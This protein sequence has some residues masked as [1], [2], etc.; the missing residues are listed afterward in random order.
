MKRFAIVL[1]IG[2]TAGLVSLWAADVPTYVGA[3][4]CRDCHKT[5]KQGKQH[6]LWEAGKHAQSFNNLKPE[7]AK[8]AAGAPIPAQQAPGC[9]K[10]HAPLSEKAAAVSVEGVTCEVCHGP[11]SQYRKLSVMVDREACI[12]NGLVVYTSP[13]AVKAHCL[14]CHDNAHGIAFDFPKAWDTIKHYRPGK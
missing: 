8:D 14:T 9:L 7:T 1:G 2:L 4:K 13:D 3:G 12:K 10:C 11:G 5:E 6:P